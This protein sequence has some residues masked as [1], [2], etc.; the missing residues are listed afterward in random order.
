MDENRLNEIEGKLKEFQASLALVKATGNDPQVTT[1][2]TILEGAF[3][4]FQSVVMEEIAKVRTTMDNIEKRQAEQEKRQVEL[5]RREAE[6][7]ERLDDAEQYSRRMC[8]LLRGV[9]ETPNRNDNEE[10]CLVHVMKLMREKLKLNLSEEVVSRCHRLGGRRDEQ[11]RGRPIIVKFYSYRHRRAVFGA[12]KLLKDSPYSLSE[13]L[14][15]NRMKI[16]RRAKDI[17][18]MR[19][20]WTSD[21]KICIRIKNNNGSFDRVVVRR[22]DDIPP[23]LDAANI[24]TFSL[25]TRHV[26]TRPRT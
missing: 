10:E 12:K 6:V 7:E 17:H 3:Q 23:S 26:N 4:L 25:D 2:L 22:M 13:F 18:G 5:E 16:F 21:G 24:S 20:C 19:S 1:S 15:V 9:P 8:L 14:T 11:G